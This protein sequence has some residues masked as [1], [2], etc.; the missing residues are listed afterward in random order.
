VSGTLP[1]ALRLVSLPRWDL[2]FCDAPYADDVSSTLA[3]LGLSE[4]VHAGTVVAVEVASGRRP[5]LGA[6]WRLRH[7]RDDG[8]NEFLFLV[9]GS[10]AVPSS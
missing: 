6:A 3:A 5:A 2:V 4:R 9:P 8:G 7:A 10:T 1:H